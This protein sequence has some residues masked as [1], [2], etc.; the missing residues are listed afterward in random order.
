MGLEKVTIIPFRPRPRMRGGADTP[1]HTL[2]RRD[3]C[4]A[5]C[6]AWEQKTQPAGNCAVAINCPVRESQGRWGWPCHPNLAEMTEGG[7]HV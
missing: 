6:P 4:P 1:A 7:G 5:Y 2:R 3:F